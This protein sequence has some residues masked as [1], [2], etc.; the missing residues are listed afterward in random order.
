MAMRRFLSNILYIFLALPITFSALLLVSVR[1]WALDRE[2]YKR[3]VQDDRLYAALQAPELA[4][5]AP[6]TLKIG[7]ATFDGPALAT[8][9]QK[10]LPA[11]EIKASAGKAIDGVMDAVASGQADRVELDMRPIKAALRSRSAAVARDYAAALASEKSPSPAALTPAAQMPLALGAAIDA[12][13]DTA[14]PSAP[15][16]PAAMRRIGGPIGVLSRG[17]GLGGQGLSQAILNRTTASS[18]AISALLLAGLGALGGTSLVSRLSRA[19]RYLLFPSILVL[20][21]GVALAIPG[22]LFQNLLPQGIKAM[23]AGSAGAQ[24]RAYLASALGPIAQGFFI[25]GL[26]GAS[27]GGV[28]A[29]ARKFAEPKELE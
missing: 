18:L 15:N 20:G 1:P 6:E 25:S 2:T 28:L 12:L 22:G 10:N 7:N 11:A 19:G 29:S 21:V 3:F 14:K 17:D 16:S 5:R 26:V 9:V 24:L 23:V 13:P 27:L 8:A 4:A